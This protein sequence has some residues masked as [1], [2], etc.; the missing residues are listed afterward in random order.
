MKQQLPN[1]QDT[2][3]RIKQDKDA[4]NKETGPAIQSIT[5]NTGRDL[6]VIPLSDIFHIAF[7][8]GITFIYTE[9]ERYLSNKYLNYYENKLND[10]FFRTSRNDIIH[11]DK[12]RTIHPM[13][14]G[15]YLIELSNGLKIN[16]SRRRARDLRTIM[17]F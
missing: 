8:D 5:I 4:A 6:K 2:E 3:S 1:E 12:I 16:L 15:T 10:R 13:F 14:N 11:L 9:N 7:E 17:D